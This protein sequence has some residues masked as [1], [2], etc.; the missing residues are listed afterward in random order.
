LIYRRGGNFVQL[1]GGEPY[2]LHN[3]RTK[4][5]GVYSGRLSEDSDL[6]TVWKVSLIATIAERGI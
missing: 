4:L 6:G 5:L 3:P 2:M 1:A